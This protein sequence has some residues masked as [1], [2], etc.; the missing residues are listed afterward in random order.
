MIQWFNH[1]H[2]QYSPKIADPLAPIKIPTTPQDSLEAKEMVSLLKLGCQMNP[3]SNV[4]LLLCSSYAQTKLHYSLPSQIRVNVCSGQGS[5]LS[6]CPFAASEEHLCQSWAMA[7]PG[8]Q[9][10]RP[11]SSYHI[12]G[13][14]RRKHSSGWDVGFRFSCP[15][16]VPG[17]N[18]TEQGRGQHP[19]SHQEK[20]PPA[21][22]LLVP[23]SV[24]DWIKWWR[25][26]DLLCSAKSQKSGNNSN[27]QSWIFSEKHLQAAFWSSKDFSLSL[28]FF[29]PFSF[30]TEKSLTNNHFTLYSSSI[31]AI[32]PGYVIN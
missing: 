4:P 8:C 26:V 20:L 7:V 22:L 19:S 16:K 21:P 28:L 1:Q 13:E 27:S 12:A 30:T 23:V 29:P 3:N 15:N 5:H 9:W 11:M 32:T 14:Q 2:P 18:G 17:F 31:K 25:K 24:R 10:Q 6:F